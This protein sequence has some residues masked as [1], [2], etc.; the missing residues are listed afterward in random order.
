MNPNTNTLVYKQGVSDETE[1]STFLS[2]IK[3]E[4]NVRHPH[5]IDT[6]YEPLY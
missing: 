3:T 4:K 2:K 1:Y 6:Y 5:K